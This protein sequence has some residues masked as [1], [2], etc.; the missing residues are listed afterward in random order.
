MADQVFE[1]ALAKASLTPKDAD[2]A[3]ALRIALFLREC[4][5]RL[6]VAPTDANP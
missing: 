3:A 5:A 1:T 2:R 4:R 6:I